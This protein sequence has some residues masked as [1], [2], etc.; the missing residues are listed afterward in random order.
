[1]KSLFRMVALAK[2]YYIHLIIGSVG[3]IVMTLAQLYTP[4]V[5]K[6]LFR[7]IGGR[8]WTFAARSAS[9]GGDAADSL[10]CA[11]GW[12]IPAQLFYALRG[13]AFYRRFARK[14]VS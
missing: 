2:K 7:M 4:Q 5:L 11:G 12:T 14:I 13:V 8:Q 1:M 3:L 6:T 10:F 9:A